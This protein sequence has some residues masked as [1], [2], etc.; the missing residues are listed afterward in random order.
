MS[1]IMKAV[2]HS[3]ESIQM[4]KH[5]YTHINV[6]YI[7]SSKTRAQNMLGMLKKHKQTNVAG[8][9]KSRVSG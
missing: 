7:R 5:L 1:G 8:E 6:I 9:E 2:L 3:G 4:V